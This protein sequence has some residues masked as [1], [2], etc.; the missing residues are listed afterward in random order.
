MIYQT[1]I[2]KPYKCMHALQACFF[3]PIFII[4]VYTINFL[5]FIISLIFSWI[6]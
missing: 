5:F 3:P 2:Y 1:Q 4:L 6:A